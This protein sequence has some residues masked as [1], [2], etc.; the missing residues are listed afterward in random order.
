MLRGNDGEVYRTEIKAV[1][2]RI[3]QRILRRSRHDEPD[4]HGGGTHQ[5]SAQPYSMIHCMMSCHGMSC[6]VGRPTKG[7]P[8]WPKLERRKSNMDKPRTATSPRLAKKISGRGEQSNNRT[9][10]SKLAYLGVTL[11]SQV[12]GTENATNKGL[13]CLLL[14]SHRRHA[15]RRISEIFS[16][17]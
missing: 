17:L 8:R 16:K 7:M 11:L 14:E 4:M 5:S 15:R 13:G 10:S 1:P 3:R 6:H 9:L 2:G 12:F